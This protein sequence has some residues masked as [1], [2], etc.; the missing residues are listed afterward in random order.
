MRLV[1]YKQF[2]ESYKS[3][4]IKSMAHSFGVSGEFIDKELS[5]F[6]ASGKI[7]CV[8]DKVEGIIESN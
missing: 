1:A 2:L 4:T 8:I 3:V 5:N 6:I 7:A